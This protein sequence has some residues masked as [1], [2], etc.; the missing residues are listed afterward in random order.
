MQSNSARPAL[1]VIKSYGP[2]IVFALTVIGP[3][4]FVSN[5]ATGASHGYLLLWALLISVFFRYVWLD[6]S[7]RYVMA[8]GETLM[9]GYARFGPW[10][11]YVVLAGMFL[12]R[13]LSNLFKIVLLINTAELL[14]PREIAP[15]PMMAGCL[16][17]FLSYLIC[18]RGGYP[19][20]E[21][22]FKPLIALM[23]AAVLAAAALAQPD[24]A[25]ML[26]GL[27][28][29]S[30]PPDSGLYGTAFLL[31]ALVGTEA[32]SL[33]NITYSYFLWQKG[34]RDPSHQPQQR[35]DLWLSVLSLFFISASV[36]IAAAGILHPAGVSPKD[37]SDLAV[38]FS[39]SLGVTGKVIFTFGLCAAA[40]SGLI[41]ATTG[42]SLIL[43]DIW[44]RRTGGT[45][46]ADVSAR[47]YRNSAAFWCFAPLAL[48]MWS[49]RPVWLVLVVSALMAAFIPVL[50]IFLFRLTSNTRR[51]GIMANSIRHRAAFALLI[52]ASA[53]LVAGNVFYFAKDM[54]LH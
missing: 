46:P 15:H 31:M 25:A 16:L 44:R 6:A 51:M 11:V 18:V 42:Y 52:I 43:A 32:G 28:L 49:N 33:T 17:A 30:F 54:F 34:W 3:G 1:G 10:L 35:R 41:G 19:A 22:L 40:F 26:S 39:H 23:C 14:L 27:F 48:L 12:I 53:T 29:P 50:A 20:L 2:G 47:A 8:T 13:T 7:A 38:L 9:D 37:S 21:R 45:S 36:Q 24:P 4:D 5:A